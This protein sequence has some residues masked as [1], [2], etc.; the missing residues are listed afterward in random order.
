MGENKA[1][2]YYGDDKM[3]INRLYFLLNSSDFIGENPIF[4]Y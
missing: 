2:L 3:N 1:F 4:G